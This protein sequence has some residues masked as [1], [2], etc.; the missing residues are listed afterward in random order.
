MKWIVLVIAL[1][2]FEGYGQLYK[3]E[4]YGKTELGQLKIIA[5]NVYLDYNV[6]EMRVDL[7]VNDSLYA[8]KIKQVGKPINKNRFTVYFEGTKDCMLW[9]IENEGDFVFGFQI[10][11]EKYW[12]RKVSNP[13][14]EEFEWAVRNY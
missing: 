9:N 8:Y 4:F 3:S 7:L 10:A 12:F 13:L 1:I 2:S 11:E 5:S 14:R 6:P